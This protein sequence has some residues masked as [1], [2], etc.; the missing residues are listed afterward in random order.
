[1]YPHV[2]KGRSTEDRFRYPRTCSML[3][4][5]TQ[6]SESL[7]PVIL[8]RITGPPNNLWSS[9]MPETFFSCPKRQRRQPRFDRRDPSDTV[10]R[11]RG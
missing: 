5:L 6:A 8:A 2:L 9:V 1:M 7:R 11:N 10:C 3:R 4:Q